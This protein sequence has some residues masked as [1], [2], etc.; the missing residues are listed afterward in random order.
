MANER[1]LIPLRLVPMCALLG[2]LLLCAAELSGW[3][4][5]LFFLPIA[6]CMLPLCEEHL[7]GY[8]VFCD[9]LIAAIVLFLPVP[10]YAWLAFVCVLAPYVPLRHAFRE[11]KDPRR[12]TLLSILIVVLWTALVLVGLHFLGVE[13]ITLLS[14]LITA[15][16]AL[17]LVFFL[18]LLDAAYHLYLKAYQNRVRRFLL[19]HA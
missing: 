5:L 1:Q 12:A 4:A 18:F 13:L 14:P 3:F 7:G 15:L 11:L 2:L 19:P 16:I 9:V 10:H 17:G 6:L 8:A